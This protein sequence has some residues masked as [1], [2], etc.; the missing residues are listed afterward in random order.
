MASTLYRI[1]AKR[2]GHRCENQKPAQL[3]RKFVNAS[4]K[5]EITESEIVVSYGRR[6]YNPFL[7]GAGL[8]ETAERLPWLGGRTLRLRAI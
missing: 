5:V 3:C 7:A 1:L 2:I 8:F 6:A 4:A